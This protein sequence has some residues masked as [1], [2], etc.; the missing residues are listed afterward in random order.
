M[1]RDVPGFMDGLSIIL[2]LF[3]LLKGSPVSFCFSENWWNA[4][5]DAEDSGVPPS[6]DLHL[7]EQIHSCVS[8]ETL[9]PGTDGYSNRDEKRLQQTT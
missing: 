1:F 5:C 9:R 6:A 2:L 7:P 3:F 8:G 4:W